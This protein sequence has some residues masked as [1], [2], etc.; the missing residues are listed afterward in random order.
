MNLWTSTT[1]FMTLSGAHEDFTY[2]DEPI[3]CHQLADDLQWRRHDAGFAATTVCGITDTWGTTVNG[4][5]KGFCPG[6]EYV[7]CPMCDGLRS[8]SL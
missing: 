7:D 6:A 4:H 1:T 5:Q 8:G 2:D 3:I